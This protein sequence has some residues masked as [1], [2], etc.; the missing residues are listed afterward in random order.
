MATKQIEVDSLEKKKQRKTEEGQLK[1]HD[2]RS[3]DSHQYDERLEDADLKN[4]RKGVFYLLVFNE[5]KS[6]IGHIR[7]IL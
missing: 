2:D 6:N 3:H 4:K 7:H 1:K 5:V